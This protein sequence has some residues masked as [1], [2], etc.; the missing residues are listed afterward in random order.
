[1]DLWINKKGKKIG[2]QKNSTEA[3]I[4]QIMLVQMAWACKTAP[5]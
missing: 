1:M 5:V 4:N 3:P 2:T